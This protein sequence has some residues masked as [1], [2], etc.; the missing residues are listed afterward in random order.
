MLKQRLK[1]A[2]K[3]IKYKFNLNDAVR[4]AY[5]RDPFTKDFEEQYSTEVF[6]ISSRISPFNTNRYTIKNVNNVAEKGTFLE[7]ELQLVKV[8]ENSLYRVEKIIGR[9]AINGVAYVRVKWLNYN[10]SYNSWI[11]ASELVNLGTA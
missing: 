11:P 2:S 7:V 3:F 10:A 9:K 8:S 5:L 6:F 4:V 1:K